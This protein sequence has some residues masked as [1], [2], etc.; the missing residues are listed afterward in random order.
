MINLRPLQ[1]LVALV[2]SHFK[3]QLTWLVLAVGAGYGIAARSTCWA[4]W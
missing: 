4:A 1:M 3:W 2:Q